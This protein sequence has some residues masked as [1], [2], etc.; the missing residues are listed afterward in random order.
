M[1]PRPNTQFLGPPESTTKRHLN[2]F[3]HFRRA[4]DHER[5]TTLLRL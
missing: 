3:N 2:Q 4:H 5:K 1:E